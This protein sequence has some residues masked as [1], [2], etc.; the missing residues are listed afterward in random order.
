MDILY[1]L[2]K[3]FEKQLPAPDVNDVTSCLVTILKDFEIKYIR[4]NYHRKIDNL[5]VNVRLRTDGSTNATIEAINKVCS[6]YFYIFEY[7]RLTDTCFDF[8]AIPK[9]KVISKYGWVNYQTTIG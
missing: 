3:P 8:V 9:K 5:V 1:I 7:D 6:R 2:K 4:H